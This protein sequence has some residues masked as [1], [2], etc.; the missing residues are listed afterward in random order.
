MAVGPTPPRRDPRPPQTTVT[1]ELAH[2]T[3]ETDVFPA[4][5][6]RI[7][8]TRFRF[9]AYWPAAHAFFGPVDGR[10]QDPMIVG[11]TLRQASMVLA[12]AEFGAPLD[13]HFV[14]GDL[15]VGTDPAA[16]R[17]AEADEP[18][19][20]DVE[21]S[22]VRRRG[23]G[24]ASMRTTM[25]FR[26]AGRFVAR[27]TGSTGCT[28][29]LAYRR[30][31]AGRLDAWDTPVPPLPGLAPEVVGRS[32]AADVL[33]APT[34]RPGVWRL[35]V[36]TGHP[37][38]FPRPNDHVPGMALFEAARQAAAAASGLRPFL[39]RSLSVVFARYT[40]LHEPCLLATEVLGADDRREVTVRVTGRQG[41]ESVFTAVLTCARTV[42]VRSLG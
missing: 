24:L 42:P 5:W 27:G 20:I 17:L 28:S 31:R 40:E 3:S 18:V 37:N 10:H 21:C 6:H 8:D 22:E 4:R 23:R 25:E 32:R 16:L 19:E 13:T 34:G 9:T 1:R 30:L 39:P 35:R 7:S 26:R 14:M 2:R 38:L 11:E 33:L 41:G 12:H 15:A 36:D 29:P